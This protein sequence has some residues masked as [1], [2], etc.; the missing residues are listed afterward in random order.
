LGAP[1]LEDAELLERGPWLSELCEGKVAG[2]A[3]SRLR[4]VCSERKV[5]T[6]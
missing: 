3:D 6:D 5:K 2:S 4:G 1:P